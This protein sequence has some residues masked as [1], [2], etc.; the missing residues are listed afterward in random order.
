VEKQVLDSREKLEYYR[1]K[2]QD[3]V[4]TIVIWDQFGH[5]IKKLF[6]M[7]KFLF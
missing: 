2:M 7:I 3:L 5:D 6:L 4:S 1:S